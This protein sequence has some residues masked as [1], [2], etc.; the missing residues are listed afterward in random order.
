MPTRAKG[1]ASKG[2]VSRGDGIEAELKLNSQA[3]A[4][5]VEATNTK[6]TPPPRGVG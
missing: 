5:A 4:L 3:R 1:N 6:A 2:A